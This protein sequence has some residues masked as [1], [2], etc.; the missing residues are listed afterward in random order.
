MSKI[1]GNLK[2]EKEG[3]STIYLE[4]HQDHRIYKIQKEDEYMFQKKRILS[5][6][7]V[8]SMILSLLVPLGNK[9][10]AS[11]F[12]DGDFYV[13]RDSIRFIQSNNPDI[14]FRAYSNEDLYAYANPETFSAKAKSTWMWFRLKDANH[15]DVTGIKVSKIEIV[16]NGKVVA[17]ANDVESRS[18]SGQYTTGNLEFINSFDNQNGDNLVD[19]VF[20][21][22][23][24]EVA[25]VRDFKLGIYTDPVVIRTYPSTIG[26]QRE[27]FALDIV[28]INLGHDDIVDAYLIDNAGNKIT[29]IEKEI[30]DYNYGGL[31]RNITYG[32]SFLG[33][34][35]LIAEQKYRI[36]VTVNGNE[37][38]NVDYSD[39]IWVSD[40]CRV[41]TTYHPGVRELE[42]WV[43][44]TN[45][46][47]NGPY[48][49]IIKQDDEITGEIDGIEAYF[50]EETYEETILV[51]L[52]V[53]YFSKY[54]GMYSTE[55]YNGSGELIHAFR[56]L[57][58]VDDTSD[59]VDD[60]DPFEG[61]DVFEKM[62]N[63]EPTKTW[64]I[65]FNMPL[66]FESINK[67]NVYVI[68]KNSGLSIDVSY[69]IESN[70]KIIALTPT[71]E[72]FEAGR[73]YYLIIE[74]RVKS[75]N[76]NSLYKPVVIEFT[77]RD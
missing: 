62:E 46:T 38:R 28:T 77:I 4:L 59:I 58:P 13:D 21:L 63:V 15:N 24:R 50:N 32:I 2:P 36:I 19:I 33:N 53:E 41:T 26:V 18:I 65:K 1:V 55:L 42:F 11:S 25:R 57:E 52:G 35:Y 34:D 70:D 16:Q 23:S 44:G 30:E 61:Y 71:N 5:L 54:G 73:T 48:K 47:N 3:L 40:E 51:P 72:T 39:Y 49:L 22:G 14:N 76:G 8:L 6:I 29:K 37:I 60:V 20:Y 75:S 17:R 56:F 12:H 27:K 45:L 68:E 69:E 74:G 10:E 9:V 64:K 43:E 66:D 31:E 7:I 67:S